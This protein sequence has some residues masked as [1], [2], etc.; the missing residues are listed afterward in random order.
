MNSRPLIS[1]FKFK[2]FQVSYKPWYAVKFSKYTNGY[3]KQIADYVNELQRIICCM[4][5]FF[6]HK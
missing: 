4:N 1:F 5:N 2:D 3:L 6:L